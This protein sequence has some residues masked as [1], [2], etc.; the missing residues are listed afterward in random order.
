MDLDGWH[1]L[2]PTPSVGVVPMWVGVR[3]LDLWLS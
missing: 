2:A 3:D 1:I